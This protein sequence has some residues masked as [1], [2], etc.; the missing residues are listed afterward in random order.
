VTPR[1]AVPRV[2]VGGVALRDRRILLVRRAT[3][4]A[5]GRWS[6]PGGHVELG[7]DVRSALV[8]EVHEE[9][10]LTVVVRS[11]VGWTERI[12]LGADPPYHFVILDF[13]VDVGDP[14]TEPAAASDAAD[15]AWVPLDDLHAYA[16][17]E[18]LVDFLEQHGVL[19]SRRR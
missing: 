16:L 19:S 13:L 12:D 4:P 7:E 14:D 10:G 1:P 11:L 6:L 17:T 9:T 3:A 2:A 15:A 8:R 18:G 5:R